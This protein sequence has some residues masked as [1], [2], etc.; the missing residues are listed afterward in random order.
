MSY[1]VLVVDDVPEVAQM[2][3]AAL[4]PAGY[5]VQTLTDATAAVATVAAW[6][7]DLLLLDVMLGGLNA[8]QVL[9]ALHEAGYR[10]PVILMSAYI[11]GGEA[12][13]QFVA[14]LAEWGPVT[15]CPKPFDLARLTATV[16]RVL[17]GA[18]L[19]AEPSE[20]ERRQR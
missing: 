7:P 10:P 11:A 14:S 8:L 4:T 3:E 12:A 5:T 18:A 19:K 6:R 13:A 16:A 2:L 1:R 15:L 9:Q 20:L 17:A